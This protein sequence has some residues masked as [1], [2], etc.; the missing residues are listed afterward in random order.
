MKAD[1][2]NKLKDEILTFVLPRI[3]N[4]SGNRIDR[5]IL[6]ESIV[7]GLVLSETRK[8]INAIKIFDV[9]AEGVKYRLNEVGDK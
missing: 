8:T 2:H 5:M 1:V 6:I 3:M 9:L 7:S 4:S